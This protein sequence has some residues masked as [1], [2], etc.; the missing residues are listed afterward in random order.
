M[1]FVSFHLKASFTLVFSL[2]TGIIKTLLIITRKKKKKHDKIQAL[3]QEL[4]DMECDKIITE[5]KIWEDKRQCDEYQ[6]KTREK[7]IKECEFK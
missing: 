7:E 6:W 3:S 2:T 5:K 1:E 4:T